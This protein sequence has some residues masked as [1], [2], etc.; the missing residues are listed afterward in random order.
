MN[1]KEDTTYSNLQNKEFQE[2]I[3]AVNAFM[4]QERYQINNLMMKNQQKNKLNSNLSKEENILQGK[5]EVNEMNR[6]KNKGTN[7]GNSKKLFLGQYR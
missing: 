6:K 5:A 7:N 3:T 4:K 2:C 1:E